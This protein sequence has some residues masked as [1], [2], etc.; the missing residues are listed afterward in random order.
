MKTG[1]FF[2]LLSLII[3]IVY[4]DFTYILWIIRYLIIS[5]WDV[6]LNKIFLS[7]IT[8]IYILGGLMFESCV[9]KF[10]NDRLLNFESTLN[11]LVVLRFLSLYI[12]FIN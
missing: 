1:K 10:K 12:S 11:P 2:I 4:S 6:T 5:F 8:Y 3:E 9:Y 7:K